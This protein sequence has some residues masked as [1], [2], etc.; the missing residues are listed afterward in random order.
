MFLSQRK[1]LN[2]FDS[3]KNKD[4]IVFYEYGAHFKYKNLYDCLNKLKINNSYENQKK[5]NSN[6]I[7]YNNI[8]NG[9]DKSRNIQLNN[10]IR[11]I[12][13]YL[14]GKKNNNNDNKTLILPK[15]EKVKER[16]NNHIGKMKKEKKDNKKNSNPKIRKKPIDFEIFNISLLLY[17][18][19]TLKNVPPVI[20]AIINIVNIF[21]KF[22]CGFTDLKVGFHNVINI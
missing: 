16:I 14:K 9:I 20:K 18:Y 3:E 13:L 5:K 12:N 17:A 10:Y 4:D 22:K 6:Y 1:N 2:C 15:A 21:C 8:D 7:N 11:S 19:N